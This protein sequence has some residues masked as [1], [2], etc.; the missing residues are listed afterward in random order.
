MIRWANKNFST[1]ILERSLCALVRFFCC[2][3]KYLRETV[4]EARL[5]GSTGPEEKQNIV[6]VGIWQRRLLNS[7]SRERER[8]RDR[9]TERDRDKVHLSRAAPSDLIA[10]TR[11]H[12]LLSTAPQ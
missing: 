12:L 5:A 1:L 10:P 6:L 8:E 11:P 3:E 2:Y 9:Q 7:W 4:L